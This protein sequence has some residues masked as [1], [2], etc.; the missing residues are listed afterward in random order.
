MVAITF[1]PVVAVAQN[2]GGAMSSL[3][4]A[5][6]QKLMKARQEVFASNPALKSEHEQLAQER[7]SLKG[8]NETPQQKKAFF[9]QMKAHEEKM[10]AAMLQV[11]PSLAPVFSQMEVNR[12]QAMQNRKAQN[13][14]TQ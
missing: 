6:K 13:G 3:S 5:D 4:Q 7:Q 1:L 9:E 2:G 11:D 8:S 10:K 12:Q 14:N